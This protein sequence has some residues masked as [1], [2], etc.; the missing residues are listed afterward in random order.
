MNV[1]KIA[2]YANKPNLYAIIMSKLLLVWYNSLHSY[3]FIGETLNQAYH[4]LDTAIHA[5]IADLQFE[6]FIFTRYAQL[7]VQMPNR[8]QDVTLFSGLIA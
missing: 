3:L 1:I 6:I 5:G 7:T 4:F 2:Y 8:R